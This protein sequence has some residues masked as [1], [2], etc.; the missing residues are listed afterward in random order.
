MIDEWWIGKDLEGSGDGLIEIRSLNLFGDWR[1]PM[2]IFNQ[3]RRCPAWDSS[4]PL[5]K[6]EAK[7]L[8][9]QQSGLYVGFEVLALVVMQ[10]AC[11]LLSRW[12]LARLIFRPWRWRR[13]VLPKLLSTFN[14]LHGIISQKIELFNPL[15]VFLNE[16]KHADYVTVLNTVFRSPEPI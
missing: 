14:G 7:A 15:F 8:P 10:I 5:F 16:G 9:I 1:S 3:T 2:K 4:Q 13:Y 12:F 6:Y 11:H